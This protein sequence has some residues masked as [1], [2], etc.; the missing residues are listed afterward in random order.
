MRYSNPQLRTLLAGEYALGVLSPT[1][2]RRFQRLLL[3]DAGLQNEVLFWEQHL[4][5]WA[6]GL[7]PV[8]PD[9][10]VWH[11]ISA[12]LDKR[13]SDQ[14]TGNI[15]RWGTALSAAAALVLAVALFSYTPPV[16]PVFSPTHAAVFSTEAGQPVWIIEADLQTGEVHMQALAGATPPANKS[17]ELWMLPAE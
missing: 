15:W 13:S 7:K 10:R 11:R 5:Q 4:A 14:P 1:A 6:A 2:R 8:M 12:K 9:A 3:T 16:P 17:Y